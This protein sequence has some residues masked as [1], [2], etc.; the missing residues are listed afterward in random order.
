MQNRLVAIGSI[1][2]LMTYFEIFYTDFI[3]L[4]TLH[5]DVSKFVLLSHT[6]QRL[7]K[8]IPLFLSYKW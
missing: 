2:K 7:Q 4:Y 1:K 8:S 3:E 6:N 5:H